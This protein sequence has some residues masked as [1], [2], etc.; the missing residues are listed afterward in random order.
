MSTGEWERL[1]VRVFQ[2]GNEEIFVLDL[3]GNLLEAVE[4]SPLFFRELERHRVGESFEIAFPLQG[5]VRAKLLRLGEKLLAV[6][7]RSS[8]HFPFNTLIENDSRDVFYRL[9]LFPERYFEY[10]SP[11]VTSITGYTPQDHYADPDLVLKIIHPDDRKILSEIAEGKWL[12]KPLSLRW[13]RKDGT[14]IWTEQVNVPV[15]DEVGNLIAL[16]GIAR[17]ITERKTL[18]NALQEKSQEFEWLLE[19]MINAFAVHEAVFDERGCFADFR[20]LYVN[21][22]YEDVVGV[23]RE[24]IIG[25]T[26]REL[27][28]DMEKEWFMHLGRVAQ[29]GIPQT[30]ELYHSSTRR[31]YRCRAYRPWKEGNR[32]CVVFDDVTK[33]QLTLERAIALK[34]SLLA[35][36][37][38]NQLITQGEDPHTL[39][40]GACQKL[41][42]A[43]E[44]AYAWIALL[45]EENQVTDFAVSGEPFRGEIN[46]WFSQ[47]NVPSCVHQA[48]K[49]GPILF[50]QLHLS[51]PECPLSA[52]NPGYA[53]VI[54]PLS[55]E[56]RVYGVLGMSIPTTLADDREA[57]DLL[58]EVA[59][60]LGFALY[61]IALRKVLRE[62]E[63]RY[64]LL[65]ENIPGVVY[66]CAPSLPWTMHYLNDHIEDLTGYPKEEFLAGRITYATLCHPEDIPEMEKRITQAL[67][68]KKPF[69]LV[70]RLRHRDGS[71]RFVEEWGAGIFAGETVQYLEGFIQDVTTRELARERLE[72]MVTHDSLTGLYN[73]Q[74][75]ENL[76]ES[77]SLSYPVGLILCDINGLRLVNDAFGQ[78]RGDELLSSTALL[79]Q[80][81]MPKQALLFRFGSDEF[82][83]LIP[84]ASETLLRDLSHTLR[85]GLGNIHLQGVPLS[86]SIGWSLWE[87]GSEPFEQVLSRAEQWLHLRKLT[88]TQSA[89]SAI[90]NL[91]I[92][93][94]RETTQ[95]TEIHAR[96]MVKLAR[97]LGETLHLPEKDLEELEFLAQLHDLG[98]IAIPRAI[99]DKPGP[100]TPEEWEIVKRHPEVGFRIA[101]ASPD[102]AP[103]APAIL[104]HHERYDG[105]GYPRGLRGEEIPLLA[106][107]LAV[108]D[109]YDV[110]RSGR[111]YKPPM[112]EEEALVELQRFAGTQFDPL[113]VDTF[114]KIIEEAE[115]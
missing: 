17:D 23:K 1:P 78:K 48:L 57:Q 14:I 102:L 50:R 72:Y 36:R 13:V 43:M 39:I 34:R 65:V 105:T 111:P 41:T 108:V 101:Q 83:S 8:F 52:L 15:Y 87:D 90:L 45:D 2:R 62:T 92:R 29:T 80:D 9:H 67:E 5:K 93:S 89:H 115:R 82:L 19:H 97:L 91:T 54:L 64:Q 40:A 10:V 98:K 55:F 88:E 77:E 66:L 84:K 11:S 95:E 112:T 109:A 22:A 96:R 100:L 18:E 30:F 7:F 71:W 3:V 42:E 26:A 68:T 59:Q 24:I 99:L 49:Y 61:K 60:D 32:Y 74:F 53:G 110:M 75:L 37:N 76:L 20:I 33:E 47:G 73:R 46:R 79:L 85:A 4:K 81:L 104:A 106:R 25:R 103:I 51:C 6:L 44:I 35:I 63:T 21:R 70:Y 107:I 58:K 38:V 69:H 12:G 16:E 94:L 27:W 28:P 56:K 113:V 114:I 31:Y 86:L